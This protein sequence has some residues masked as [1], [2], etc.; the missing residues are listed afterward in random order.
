MLK[1]QK[2]PFLLI[3]LASVL[4]GCSNVPQTT[5]ADIPL[6]HSSL[7]YSLS[8]DDPLVIN[9]PQL[10]ASFSTKGKLSITYGG[11]TYEAVKQYTS[12]S[13]NDCIRFQLETTELTDVR[14]RFTACKRRGSWAVISPLVVSTEEE[15]E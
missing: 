10:N 2:G 1:L 9:N 4:V 12:A 8:V 6:V 3:G 15:G 7:A 5:E 11:H 13:G 14:P